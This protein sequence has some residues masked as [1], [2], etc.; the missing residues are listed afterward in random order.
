MDYIKGKETEGLS[1]IFKAGNTEAI[2]LTKKDTA[3]YK[4]KPG[5]QVVK[6]ISPDGMSITFKKIPKVS[7]ETKDM[8]AEVL[9]EDK[10]LI[11]AL[12]DL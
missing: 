12:K 11:W 3:I 5:D 4:V 7:Q 6:E 2:R 1:K 10:D 9:K 8:V